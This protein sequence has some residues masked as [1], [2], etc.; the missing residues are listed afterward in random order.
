MYYPCTKFVF[1][2]VNYSKLAPSYK[3]DL[4]SGISFL[5]DKNIYYYILFSCKCMKMCL[6]K[7]LKL[8][9][10]LSIGHGVLQFLCKNIYFTEFVIIFFWQNKGQRAVYLE[11]SNNI[12]NKAFLFIKMYF[13]RLF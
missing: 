6:T 7:C 9:S 8:K 5:S 11:F 13:S 12:N 4:N 10:I 2:G 3:M 1:K